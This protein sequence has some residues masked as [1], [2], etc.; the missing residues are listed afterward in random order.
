MSKV[1]LYLQAEELSIDPSPAPLPPPSQTRRRLFQLDRS[2]KV[3]EAYAD[4]DHQR[5][6]PTPAWPRVDG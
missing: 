6:Q 1:P 5:F 3:G 2:C 4:R